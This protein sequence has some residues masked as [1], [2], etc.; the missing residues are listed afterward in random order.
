[1]NNEENTISHRQN[2]TREHLK[3]ALIELIKEK[4]YHSVTVKNIVDYAV[5]NRSTFYVHYQDKVELAEDLLVSMLQGLEA[6][7]GTPY[8]PGHK[9]Y[10]AKLNAPSFNIVSYIYNHSAFFEL[11]N[12]E[13]TLPGL[14]IGFPQ[15]IIKI[16]KNNLFLKQST[17]SRSIWSTLNVIRH[18]DFTDCFRI[19][20][21]MASKNLK[22]ILSEKSLNYRKHIFTHLGILK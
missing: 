17:I 12:F 4:G 18:M 19:G 3:K 22:R 1:M 11:I 7:V 9:F 14:H 6:S 21:K 15:T 13:D 10:T 2:R 5:Y 8:V 16:Y 20:S